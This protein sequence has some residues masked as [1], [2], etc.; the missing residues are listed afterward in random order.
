MIPHPDP[1]APTPLNCVVITVSDTRSPENDRS[2]ELIKSFL[3]TGGHVTVGYRIIPD[4]PETIA[5]ELEVWETQAVD[6]FIFNGGT[7][8]SK[9][10]RTVESVSGKLERIIPGFGEL[11]RLLSYQSIGSRAMSSR[12]I[13]GVYQ[14]KLVFCIPGSTNGVK[15]AMEKLILP[16]LVHLSQQI[17]K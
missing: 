10:D 7:G 11:F 2:G 3:Q 13:A 5:S 15:L 14:E 4:E 1:I 6:A 12:A 16:E 9:R 8:I 17:K